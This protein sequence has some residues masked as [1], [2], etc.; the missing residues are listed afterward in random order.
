MSLR[1]H[2]QAQPTET[3]AASTIQISMMIPAASQF[4]GLPDVMTAAAFSRHSAMTSE[5]MTL[6]RRAMPSGMRIRS[7]R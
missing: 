1:E 3:E 4:L 5:G 2:N 6:R 7:S